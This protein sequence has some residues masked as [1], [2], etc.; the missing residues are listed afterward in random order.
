M[1]T[2]ETKAM[3]A[4]GGVRKLNQWLTFFCVDY[5]YCGK[6]VYECQEY[7]TL[8]PAYQVF[9][10]GNWS[11]QEWKIKERIPTAWNVQLSRVESWG[12]GKAL[13]LVGDIKAYAGKDISQDPLARSITGCLLAGGVDKPI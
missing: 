13:S 11:S 10:A 7:V 8:D 4:A 2:S 9:D 5:I 3:T 1:T 6:V 12:A